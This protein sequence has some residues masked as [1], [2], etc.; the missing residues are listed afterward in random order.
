MIIKECFPVYQ[1]DPQEIY[2]LNHTT[3]TL[4]ST[5]AVF[6]KGLSQGLGLNV[7]YKRIKF[8]PKPYSM[9][10]PFHEYRP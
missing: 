3:V 9:A 1:Q 2:N 4:T 6:T 8:K 7:Q 5:R 10:K